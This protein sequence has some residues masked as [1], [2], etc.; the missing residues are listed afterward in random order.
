MT[1]SDKSSHHRTKPRRAAQ[2]YMKH[3]CSLSWCKKG[4]RGPLSEVL[5]TIL[6]LEH[7]LRW[8]RLLLCEIR[9]LRLDS[10]PLFCIRWY[11]HTVDPHFGSAF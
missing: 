1:G 2:V 7:K 10:L 11:N 9:S 3:I 5:S 4:P 6:H 8:N